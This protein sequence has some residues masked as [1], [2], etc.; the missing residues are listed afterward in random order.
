MLSPLLQKLILFLVALHLAALLYW[1]VCYR[2]MCAFTHPSP[3]PQAL[4][5]FP[6]KD[7]RYKKLS[8]MGKDQ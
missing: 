2:R 5:L 6:A 8:E 7:P 3:P 4:L 1:I